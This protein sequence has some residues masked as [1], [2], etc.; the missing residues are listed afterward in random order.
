MSTA[1]EALRRSAELTKLAETRWGPKRYWHCVYCGRVG[2]AVDHFYPTA[3]GGADE[4]QNLM[5]AC[6]SCNASKRHA[7]PIEWMRLVGVPETR[8]AILIQVAETALW[9]APKDLKITRAKLTYRTS[10]RQTG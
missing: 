10:D 9:T 6:L 7:D 2:S 5:P 8:I 3:K 1:A 4:V